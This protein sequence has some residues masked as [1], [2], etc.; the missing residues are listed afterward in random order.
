MREAIQSFPRPA[1][2]STCQRFRGETG[3]QLYS[4]YIAFHYT[5]ERHRE[6][7]L[8]SYITQRMDKDNNGNL[9][10][11]ERQ[12]V[13]EDLEE[14]ML[15]ERK[16]SERQRMFYKVSQALEAA[17]LEAPKVNVDTLWTS[18]D[19]PVT[20]RDI[21]CSEFDVNECL[22]PGFSTPISD[23]TH[24][25][26]VFSTASILDFTTRQN[27]NCGDCLIKLLLNRTP[28]GLEPLLPHTKTQ[29]KARQIVVK[30]LFRYQY[31]IVEPDALFIMVTD[32]AQLENTVLKRLIN[33]QRPVGQICLNDDVMTEDLTT[34]ESLRKTMMKVLY[35][36]APHASQFE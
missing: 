20:I 17:G 32:S 11:M 4:W 1:L 5:I 8:W 26:P 25:N 29:Y 12:A 9:D 13:I 16:V 34:I 36:L 27:P 18:L 15:K 14:G 7:L 2:Q 35:K 30:L 22:A 3:F 6:T 23:K 21:D 33:G 19:G 28:K 10:W 24:L 31:T